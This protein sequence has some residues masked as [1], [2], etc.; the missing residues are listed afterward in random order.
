MKEEEF[1]PPRAG[2]WVLM[3]LKSTL[4]KWVFFQKLKGKR[5]RNVESL[6]SYVVAWD[7]RVA[8]CDF[9]AFVRVHA[10]NRR[11]RRF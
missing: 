2:G 8:R 10:S 11:D 4:N 5:Q 7:V 3:I 6:V 1:P 9:S